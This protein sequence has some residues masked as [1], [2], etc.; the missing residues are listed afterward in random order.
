LYA[1]LQPEW[2]PVYRL[3]FASAVAALKC[4]QLGGRKGIPTL[5]ETLAFIELRE[6][7]QK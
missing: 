5:A 7:E 4:T 2:T 6:K 1:C 3:K